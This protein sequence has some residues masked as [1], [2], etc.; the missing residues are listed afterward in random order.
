MAP[1]R[2]LGGEVVDDLDPLA[3][4]NQTAGEL[5]QWIGEHIRQDSDTA[6]AATPH[7]LPFLVRHGAKWR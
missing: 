3:A 5:H 4:G 6:W 2:F 7:Q 1:D